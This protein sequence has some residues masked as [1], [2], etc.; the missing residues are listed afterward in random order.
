MKDS[1]GKERVSYEP[2]SPTTGATFWTALQ[3]TQ[4]AQGAGW[5]V[6]GEVAELRDMPDTYW[7]LEQRNRH[8]WYWKRVG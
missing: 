2:T 8:R 1:K 7:T 5:T 4:Y 3:A 6:Q